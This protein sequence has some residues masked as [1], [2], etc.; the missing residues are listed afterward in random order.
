MQ[1]QPVEKTMS[2]SEGALEVERVHTMNT[3]S[4]PKHIDDQLT[5]DERKVLKRAT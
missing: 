3:T 2:K 5:V 1:H 4:E